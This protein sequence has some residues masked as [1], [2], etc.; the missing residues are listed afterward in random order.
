LAAGIAVGGAVVGRTVDVWHAFGA[1]VA[2]AL[3][4][5][6]LVAGSLSVPAAGRPSADEPA[7]APEP[8][9]S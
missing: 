5:V 2:L 9:P 8:E 4:G 6:V 7:V 1:F 3:A